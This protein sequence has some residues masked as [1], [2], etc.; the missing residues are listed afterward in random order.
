MNQV[1]NHIVKR[2]VFYGLFSAVVG[3]VESRDKSPHDGL[4]ERA[5]LNSDEDYTEYPDCTSCYAAEYRK[6]GYEIDGSGHLNKFLQG[7]SYEFYYGAE[8]KNAC[9]SAATE[10]GQILMGEELEERCNAYHLNYEDPLWPHAEKPYTSLTLKVDRKYKFKFKEAVRNDGAMHKH[11][12][13]E[14]IFSGN[15]MASFHK[16]FQKHTTPPEE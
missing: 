14:A 12:K 7:V 11:Y 6:R 5:G 9:R 2:S 3:T 10:M 4:K 16:E 1:M 15:P 13:L 8:Y